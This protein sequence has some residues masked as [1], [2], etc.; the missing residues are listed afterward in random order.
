MLGVVANPARAV[1]SARV[2]VGPT[3]IFVMALVGAW[4]GH[5]LEYLR[6][7]G[8]HRFTGVALGSVHLYMR[9]AGALL[10]VAGVIGVQSTARLARRLER[11]LTELRGPAPCR[12]GFTGLG[13]QAGADAGWS[14][15]IPTVIVV[16]WILQS[17]LYLVQE[18]AETALAH[19]PAAGVGALTGVHA[20]APLV[21][22]AVTLALV[23]G[24]CRLRRRVTQLAA[25]VRA[26]AAAL[27]AWRPTRTAAP[28]MSARTWTPVQRWGWQLWSRP[29]PIT[30]GS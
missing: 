27:R 20:L 28:S 9:P 10:L 1:R 30:V 19:A 7:W 18:N 25:A 8:G 3:G 2:D 29:P 16:V 26:A 15:S 12:A 13:R 14:F 17:M 23:G 5:N 4:L 21:H 11:R 6:V 22:L 24:V